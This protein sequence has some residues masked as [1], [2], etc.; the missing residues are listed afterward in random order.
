MILAPS[1]EDADPHGCGEGAWI[2][3]DFLKAR[4]AQR[5]VAQSKIV[6]LWNQSG[7]FVHV[8]FEPNVRAPRITA[9]AMKTATSTFFSRRPMTVLL[10]LVLIVDASASGF[11]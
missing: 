9:A 11:R 7:V 8:G 2:A 3:A 1:R 6:P 10:V 5:R 4:V